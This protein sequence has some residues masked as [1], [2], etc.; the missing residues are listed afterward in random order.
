[1]KVCKVVSG[2]ICSTSF[3]PARQQKRDF[4]STLAAM[5][6]FLTSNA[7][8]IRVTC[9]LAGYL[10]ILPNENITNKPSFFARRRLLRLGPG[11]TAGILLFFSLPK[12][13][14][15]H[16][17][18]IVDPPSIKKYYLTLCLAPD[19]TGFGY[20]RVK[21]TGVNLLKI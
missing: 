9:L 4:L 2:E 11:A 5:G 1:M 13:N 15:L 14:L 21:L 7:E 3:G 20:I 8:I 18:D 10:W 17:P 19:G 6:W 16:P 12:V